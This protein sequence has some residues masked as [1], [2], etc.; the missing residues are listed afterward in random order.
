MV[1]M[2]P[3]ATYCTSVFIGVKRTAEKTVASCDVFLE[4]ELRAEG[5]FIRF[6]FHVFVLVKKSGL[7]FL[8]SIFRAGRGLAKIIDP[9]C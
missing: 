9:H 7:M 1:K 3:L 8:G 2:S 6:S 5:V 4:R